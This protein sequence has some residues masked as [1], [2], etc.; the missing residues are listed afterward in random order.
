MR[1]VALHL[2]PVEI[3]IQGAACR[4]VFGGFEAPAAGIEE[5]DDMGLR[6]TEKQVSAKGGAVQI[7]HQRFAMGGVFLNPASGKFGKTF[8]A[9]EIVVD[10]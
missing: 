4:G 1:G 5:P 10:G 9:A 7:E 6:I 3:T 2:M 8:R